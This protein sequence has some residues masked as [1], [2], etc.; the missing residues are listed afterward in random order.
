M[1]G[2]N[3]EPPIA[4]PIYTVL[5]YCVIQVASLLDLLGQLCL[6]FE[7]HLQAEC[8][9]PQQVEVSTLTCFSVVLIAEQVSHS[10]VVL[11]I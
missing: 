8:N 4:I 9:P 2:Y 7:S 6:I 5:P 3:A 10:T 11:C 1:Y